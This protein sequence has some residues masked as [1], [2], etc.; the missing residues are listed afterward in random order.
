MKTFLLVGSSSATSNH[1]A[2][3][4]TAEGHRI[5]TIS[6]GEKPHNSTHHHQISVL[7]DELPE[8]E[9]SLDGLVYFPGSIQLK[10][11]NSMKV[12]DFEADFEI[13]VK[14]ALR[15]FQRYISALKKSGRASVVSFSTVAVQQGMPFHASVAVS[16]GAVEGLTRSLAAEFA[17]D[18]RFNCVAPSLTNTGMAS[19]LLNSPEKQTAAASKHPLK[20]YGQPE[21]L[22]NLVHFLLGDESSWIT[23]QIIHA[24]GG[25]SSLRM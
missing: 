10:P 2:E 12:E 23:G 9:D 25:L 18:I 4:L 11:F 5:I 1:L 17:P 7:H 14:G 15:C 13:N 16:K 20:R 6:R 22:A 3:R 8:I 24:D 21:D 19:R